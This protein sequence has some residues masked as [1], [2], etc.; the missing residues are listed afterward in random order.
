M[1]IEDKIPP[2]LPLAKGGITPL[3][4]MV[5]LPHHPEL[6]EGEGQ[7]E[8]PKTYVFYITDSSGPTH[9]QAPLSCRGICTGSFSFI[10][11]I[12]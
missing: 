8:I 6:V 5:R 11:K 2:P 4:Q 1:H 3:W 7:G 9:L 12:C 10:D